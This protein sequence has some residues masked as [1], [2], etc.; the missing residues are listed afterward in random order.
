MKNLFLTFLCLCV[1]MN[2]IAAHASSRNGNQAPSQLPG[3][4]I[5][6]TRIAVADAYSCYMLH[7]DEPT[8]T[9]NDDYWSFI[10]DDEPRSV[11]W[12]SGFSQSSS[13]SDPVINL[14][15]DF[16]VTVNGIVEQDVQDNGFSVSFLTGVWFTTGTVLATKVRSNVYHPILRPNQNCV[17][18][19]VRSLYAIPEQ[20]LLNLNDTAT[21]V[22][23]GYYDHDNTLFFEGGIAFYVAD[24]FIQVDTIT[25]VETIEEEASAYYL[26]PVYRNIRFLKPNGIHQYNTDIQPGVSQ[27]VL[28]RMIEIVRY[29]EP[30]TTG[31]EGSGGRVTRPIDPRPIKT[32][33]HANMVPHNITMNYIPVPAGEKGLADDNND[34]AFGSY[35]DT[36]YIAQ[37]NDS[38]VHVYNLYGA[39]SEVNVFT[40][41]ND[42]TMTLPVQPVDQ[43]T[44]HSVFAFSADSK[45]FDVFGTCMPFS[46][47]W[48]KT[49]LVNYE[50]LLHCYKDNSLSFIDGSTFYVP[51]SAVRGDVNRDGNISIA[52]VTALISTL[53]SG[54]SE[55]PNILG[56]A[57]Y[58]CNQ[59]DKITIADVTVLISYL[60]SGTW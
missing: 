43:S 4:E 32:R 28:N 7:G 55:A 49:L 8:L 37:V 41:H 21:Y 39:I 59:D 52:D 6:G 10:I 25:G 46:I 34:R 40:L 33:L 23:E 20:W 5:K 53:L 14:Y 50:D 11:G 3:F 57:A 13:L 2:T 16:D 42:Y 27:S 58:D 48:D 31:D 9:A 1:A 38:T 15:G 29:T 45:N 30:S 51:G 26:S 56:K 19:E 54:E 35:C 44:E 17:L 18:N 22:I 60:F 24:E 36:V 12:K 47:S